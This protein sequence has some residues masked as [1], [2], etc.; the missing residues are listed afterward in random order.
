MKMNTKKILQATL[1][2]AMLPLVQ[3]CM[4]GGEEL[5]ADDARFGGSKNYP[6]V[7]RNGKAQVEKCGVWEDVTET[8]Q[9]LLSPNHGCAVQHNIAAMMAKPSDLK[10]KPKIRSRNSATDVTAV[11]SIT[12]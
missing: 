7:V 8:S 3:A 2:L 6:I 12:N 5:A 10:R 11:Q 4:F 1:L 9:N